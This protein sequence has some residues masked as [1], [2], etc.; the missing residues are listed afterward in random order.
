MHSNK[1]FR[2]I[3][4]AGIGG[5]CGMIVMRHCYRS[6]KKSCA[7]YADQNFE[8]DNQQVRHHRSWRAGV[9]SLDCCFL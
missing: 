1:A 6:F 2:V 5:V 3:N 9:D 7:I 8:S 4:D